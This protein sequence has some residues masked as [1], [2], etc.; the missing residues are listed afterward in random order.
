MAITPNFGRRR[1]STGSTSLKITHGRVR[2]YF[3]HVR[4][5]FRPKSDHLRSTFP[6]RAGD[7]KVN[8]REQSCP[9]SDI[10]SP[11]ICHQ[12][13]HYSICRSSGHAGLYDC[14]RFSFRS[15]CLRCL[16]YLTLVE[17]LGSG[18]CTFTIISL[19]FD[20]RCSLPEATFERNLACDEARIPTAR[21]QTSLSLGTQRIAFTQ[22]CALLC[23]CSIS[24]HACVA[25]RRGIPLIRCVRAGVSG[26]KSETSAEPDLPIL[27]F[28]SSLVS[29]SFHESIAA[30]Q[31]SSYK[32]RLAQLTRYSKA[33]PNCTAFAHQ[34]ALHRL[35]Q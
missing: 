18:Q 15:F 20:S 4:Q 7:A 12:S 14:R 21:D 6:F 8:T 19:L 25:L 24:P 22:L 13:T 30:E 2:H 11:A 9:E 31:Q 29:T 1:W 28:R 34:S 26:S 3:Y 17:I 35:G 10:G 23:L 33:L 16:M 27:V 32:L 5:S